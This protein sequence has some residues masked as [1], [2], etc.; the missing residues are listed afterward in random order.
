MQTHQID[1]KIFG[2]PLASEEVKAVGAA[3]GR[4]GHCLLG[5]A[6]SIARVTDASLTAVARRTDVASR[7]EL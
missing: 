4:T 7:A 2:V 6:S 1:G 5:R 3:G